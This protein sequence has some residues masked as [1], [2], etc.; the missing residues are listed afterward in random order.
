MRLPA[1]AKRLQVG[2]QSGAYA[3]SSVVRHADMTR[4]VDALLRGSPA[5]MSWPSAP[6]SP[7]TGLAALVEQMTLGDCHRDRRGAR[8]S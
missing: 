5:T 8:R 2:V 7:A 3:G 6:R 4:V 1:G